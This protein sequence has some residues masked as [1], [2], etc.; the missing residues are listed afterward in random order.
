MCTAV[1]SVRRSNRESNPVPEYLQSYRQD[2]AAQMQAT[3]Q[4]LYRRPTD[5][6]FCMSLR[7]TE[8]L[9]IGAFRIVQC[10]AKFLTFCCVVV[11]F[12][13][14]SFKASPFQGFRKEFS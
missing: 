7:K 8:F 3:N 12:H 9:K 6:E 10:G 4:L 5:N 13:F 2:I 1:R 11:D 14:K